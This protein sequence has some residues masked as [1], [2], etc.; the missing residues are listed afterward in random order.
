[1]KV[2]KYFLCMWLAVLMQVFVSCSED[3]PI[4]KEQ[5]TEQG[6]SK[7]DETEGEED[8]DK[9]DEVIEE[10]IYQPY[11]TDKRVSELVVKQIQDFKDGTRDINYRYYQFTYDKEGRISKELYYSQFDGKEPSDTIVTKFTYSG[12]MIYL[13]YNHITGGFTSDYDITL[14]PRGYVS[15]Q[16]YDEDGYLVGYFVSG[17][18]DGNCR[19]RWKN[20][21]L[22]SESKPVDSYSCTYTDY[23]NDTS[24]DL[25]SFLIRSAQMR[26]NIDIPCDTEGKRSV[27][28]PKVRK[29]THSTKDIQRN[30]IYKFD[31]QKRVIEITITGSNYE[32]V[33]YY[34]TYE[35]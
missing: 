2:L 23:L 19:V 25:T 6:G 26:G 11:V 5:G 15:G 18:K 1:M 8:N 16:D 34:L 29:I 28:L 3:D 13:Q 24:L 9:E 21:N 17:Y 27:N 32:S 35:E 30:F 12:N 4:D 20:G 7:D 33:V 10:S 14:N 22:V 31:S